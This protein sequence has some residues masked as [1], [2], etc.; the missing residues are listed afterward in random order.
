MNLF[1]RENL[2]FE[3]SMKKANHEFESCMDME[4]ISALEDDEFAY[5]G[6]LSSI[7]EGL[8]KL[9]NK[10]IESISKL[11]T[12]LVDKIKS[13]FNKKESDKIDFAI[14]NF[15]EVDKKKAKMYSSEELQK[16]F[17]TYIR[18]MLKI[19][20]KLMIMS[21]DVGSNKP[22]G[23]YIIEV[24]RLMKEMDKLDAEFSEFVS[25]D[26]KHII[27][28]AKKDALRFSKKE[29]DNV[30]INYDNMAKG[31]KEILEKFKTDANGV[32]VPEQ[33]KAFQ[34]LI[35]RVSNKTRMAVNKASTYHHRNLT[36]AIA[37]SVAVAGVTI[38][39]D[40]NKREYVKRLYGDTIGKFKE[41]IKKE[42]DRIDREEALKHAVAI[43]H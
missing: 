14:N 23:K 18:E 1:A 41:N 2:E 25:S 39:I 21:I 22:N 30:R 17:D 40:P 6:T 20:R 34:S 12:S 42:F 36:T 15:V 8:V 13:V 43:R 28:M 29:L 27:E 33:R 24:N 3:L 5:E 35:N 16:R 26:N 19:E 11:I 37:L 7:A 31:S 38:G 10:A 32:Q 9:I 4:F